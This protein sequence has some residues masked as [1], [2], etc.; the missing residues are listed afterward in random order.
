MER[1]AEDMKTAMRAKD[2]CKTAVLRM[3]LSEFNYAMTSE[4][5]NSTL[6]DDQALKVK[7][8]YRKKLMKS[9]EAYPEGEK[10]SEIA[11]EIDIVAS[12]IGNSVAS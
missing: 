5:R 10:R 7:T 8:A 4:Q 2:K 12:Y 3:L 1:I 11:Q 6:E 9:L